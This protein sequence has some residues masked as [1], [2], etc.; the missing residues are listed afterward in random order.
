[1]LLLRTRCTKSRSLQDRSVRLP[2]SR[3]LDLRSDRRVS[4]RLR[5]SAY[6]EVVATLERL[7][8][9]LRN[10]SGALGVS[11]SEVKAELEAVRALL[12]QSR[13]ESALATHHILRNRLRSSRVLKHHAEDSSSLARDVSEPAGEQQRLSNR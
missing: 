6:G 13:F 1:M 9:Q 3:S 5:V 10:M 11:G 4:C 7:Q 12:V 8:L 2:F